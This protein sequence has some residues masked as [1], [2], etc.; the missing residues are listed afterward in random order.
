M[1]CS[2]VEALWDDVRTGLEPRSEHAT[3]HL[4]YC[5]DCQAVYEQYEGVAYC[6]TCLPTVEPSAQLVP[7]IYDHIKALRNRYRSKLSDS[8]SRFDSPLGVLWVAWRTS[9]ITFIG[10][11]RG[12]DEETAI[13]AIE[14]RLSRPVRL[15]DVPPWVADAL[16]VFFSTWRVDMT[17]IDISG[18]SAFEQAALRKAAEIPPGEVRSYGWI[19]REIGH[20]QAARAV[21]QAMARNP[22]ALLFP[23]HRVVDASGALHN[24]G[25]GVEVKARILEMEG[26]VKTGR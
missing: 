10:I 15:A 6:L 21:G 20:P 22:V 18:L 25:Y 19:A 14:R 4:R 16:R 24:Y 17:R 7:R 5:K 12:Q 2:D 1:R 8:I 3:A 23:C 11:D 9:G 13:A 26:Y